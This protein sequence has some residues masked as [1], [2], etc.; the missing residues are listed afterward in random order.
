MKQKSILL[1]SEIRI[2][3]ALNQ[4]AAY[5]AFFADNSLGPS[6]RKAKFDASEAGVVAEQTK[7][8]ALLA[9]EEKVLY[10]MAVD[11]NKNM[12]CP[13][14]CGKWQFHGELFSAE[15]LV[16]VPFTIHIFLCAA[17]L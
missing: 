14:C 15:G 1:R 3:V 9:E 11:L 5:N 4:F 17:L 8:K 16:C 2:C 13:V 12:M 7:M 6:E 10:E